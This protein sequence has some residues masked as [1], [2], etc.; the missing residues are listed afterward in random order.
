[1]RTIVVLPATV[2]GHHM[3]TTDAVLLPFFSLVS[4]PIAVPT[5]IKFFNWTGTSL[6]LS[7]GCGP[8]LIV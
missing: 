4:L 1:M 7:P 2:W 6:G 3:F 8:S 5:E